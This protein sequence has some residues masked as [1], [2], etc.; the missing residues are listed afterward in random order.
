MTATTR[1]ADDDSASVRLD[2][3]LGLT[4]R[5]FRDASDYRP[6][7]DLMGVEIGRAHV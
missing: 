6:M 2:P 1:P 7:A 4:Q 3:S 5:P